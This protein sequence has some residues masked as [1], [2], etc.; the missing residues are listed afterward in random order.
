MM[1]GLMKKIALAVLG[2]LAMPVL[3]DHEEIHTKSSGLSPTTW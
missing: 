1:H 2:M 3:L